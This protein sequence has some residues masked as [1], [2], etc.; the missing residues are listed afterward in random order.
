MQAYNCLSDTG[1]RKAFNSERWGR[2]FLESNNIPYESC[3][4]LLHNPNSNSEDALK[5]HKSLQNYKQV[6]ARFKDEL[7][8]IENCLRKIGA[9][10][11]SP[12]FNPCDFSFRGYPHRRTKIYKKP[13][14]LSCLQKGS[15][16]S[17]EQDKKGKCDSPIFEVRS[18][19]CL[20]KSK[21]VHFSSLS[22]EYTCFDSL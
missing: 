16:L 10:E 9:R 18:E 8:V 13:G 3:N 20:Y 6:S 4:H 11:E 1:K 17:S 2:N 22:N 19:S 21:S 14:N 7:R 5:S 12:L 15:M